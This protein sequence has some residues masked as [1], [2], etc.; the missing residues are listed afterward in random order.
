MKRNRKGALKS[1]AGVPVE[2]DSQSKNQKKWKL[3]SDLARF[4]QQQQLVHEQFLHPQRPYSR[5]E[6]PHALQLS[7]ACGSSLEKAE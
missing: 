6:R 3:V 7:A 2:N 4:L 1:T 5:Q